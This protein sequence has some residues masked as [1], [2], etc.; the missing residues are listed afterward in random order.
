MKNFSKVML[1]LVVALS[2]MCTFAFAD[3][4][5]LNPVGNAEG[6][7]ST[8]ATATDKVGAT[9]IDL[10]QTAGYVIAVVMVVI[11]GIQWLIGTPA[12]K[13]ELKGR[14][15]NVIVGAILIACGVTVLG[16]IESVGNE[17]LTSIK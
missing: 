13:Q 8:L 11:V 5:F 9:A 2:L 16:F 15:I 6:V 1:I 17:M 3:N 10:V 4:S 7:S 12:K 14:L